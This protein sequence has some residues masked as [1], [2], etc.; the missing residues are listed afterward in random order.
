MDQGDVI[1]IRSKGDKMKLSEHIEDIR[2]GLKQDKFKNEE[3]VKQGI[4]LRIL[5]ALGWECWDTKLVYPE[6]SC[7]DNT[8][9]DYALCDKFGAPK[10]FIEV[11]NI[12]KQTA[13]SEKQLFGYA[14]HKGVPIAILTDG[15]EW[16]FYLPMQTGEYSE[17]QVYKLDLLE[18]SVEECESILIQYL[19][20]EKT[21]SGEAYKVAQEEY[22][23]KAKNKIINATF[24]AA[25]RRLIDEQDDILTDMIAES[26]ETICGYKPDKGAVLDFL[27]NNVV[28]KE[29][30]KP[31]EKIKSLESS[32]RNQ[33]TAAS[34]IKECDMD[35]DLTNTTPTG[36]VIDGKRYDVKNWIDLYTE[37][38]KHLSLKNP[39][40]FEGLSNAV[41]FISNRG[42]HYFAN[43]ENYARHVRQ[44][45]ITK[46]VWIESCLSANLI[47]KLTFELIRYFGVKGFRILT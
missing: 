34:D 27:N 43:E 45:Q 8:R 11:K 32:D 17:R 24:P 18:R 22:A 10:V 47:G 6:Y 29:F 13:E 21:I 19:G 9:V 1:L 37:V 15:R 46:N 5:T 14:F 42:K 39:E 33:T 38:C 3:S 25:W 44:K 36:F 35:K 28:L 2:N 7:P 40:K 41:E 12:G 23:S 16:S 30:F 31:I 4:I 26:V 20:F